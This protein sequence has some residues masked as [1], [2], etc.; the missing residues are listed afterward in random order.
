[1]IQPELITQ[2]GT[3]T[4]PGCRTSFPW[5]RN[6]KSPRSSEPGCFCVCEEA[7]AKSRRQSQ[8]QKDTGD[9]IPRG[10]DHQMA[11]NNWQGELKAR[12]C[13]DFQSFF[14]LHTAGLPSPEPSF[15]L[16]SLLPT[17]WKIS[18]CPDPY[19]GAPSSSVMGWGLLA[20]WHQFSLD[21]R[22]SHGGLPPPPPA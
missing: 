1:M 17:Y 13:P 16:P 4:R 21:D 12:R 8:N 22:G 2:E 7:S 20:T 5:G 6:K 10:T 15:P 3:E 9:S 19:P 18:P 14:R 11:G